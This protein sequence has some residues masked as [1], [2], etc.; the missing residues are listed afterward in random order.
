MLQPSLAD[1]GRAESG[2]GSLEADGG[3]GSWKVSTA[4]CIGEEVL[5]FMLV[6]GALSTFP[7]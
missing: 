1:D 6:I 3:T 2:T 5:G 4:L 7:Y